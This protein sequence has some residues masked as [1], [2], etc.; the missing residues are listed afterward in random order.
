MYFILTRE[1]AKFMN[2]ETIYNRL[3]PVF[4]WLILVGIQ[5]SLFAALWYCANFLNYDRSPEPSFSSSELPILL[6]VFGIFVVLKILLITS[7][8]YGPLGSGDEM[9][10]Y[11]MTDSFYRGFFSI[12]QSHHYPPL[13]PLAIMPA[14][15][16]KTYAFEAIKVLNALYSSSVI[17]PAYFLARHFLGRRNSLIAVVLTCLTPYH[18]VFPR[19]ILSENLYF[20]LFIWTVLITFTLPRSKRFRLP[21]DLL[22]GAMLSVIYLTRFISL[23]AFPAFCWHGG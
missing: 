13:Y 14:L 5:I 4:A 11:D 19:R 10:Y 3:E 7:N 8:S 21:W 9:T 22:N 12:V 16:F 20:P 18:L 2:Y 23:A 17:F 15:V 6:G 1:K